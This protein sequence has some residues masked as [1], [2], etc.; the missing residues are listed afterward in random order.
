[1]MILGASIGKCVHVA[2]IMKFLSLA[3]DLG[4]EIHFLGPAVSVDKLLQAIEKYNPEIVAL[5]YRLSP[6][7]AEE[8]FKELSQGISKTG[9]KKRMFLGCTPPVAEVARKLGIFEWLVTEATPQD[10]IIAFLKG[11]K[12]KG[13]EAKYPQDL[14]ERIKYNAPFPLIRH[15]FGQPSLSDTIKGSKEIALAGVLD[16]LSLGPDQNAQEFFFR[17]NEIDSKQNGAGGVPLR[18]PDDLKVIYNATRC[19]NFPLLRCYSGT[20]DLLKWAEMSVETINNCWGAIPLSWYNR[21]DGRSKRPLPD[22]MKENQDVI[23]WYARQGVPVEVNESHQWSL[24]GAH[25][26]VAVAT[27]FLGAYN[28]KKLGVKYYVSQYM[29]NTPTGTS[30]RMDL[31][32]M[33]AKIALIEGLHDENFVSFRMVRA[34]LSSLSIIPEIAKGQMASAIYTGMFLKPHIVH[35][36]GYCEADHAARPDEIIESCK[37]A[38]GVIKDCLL[39]LPDIAQDKDIQKRKEELISESIFLLD[40]VKGLGKRKVSDPFIDTDVLT[41]AIKTGL[42]DAPNLKG[43][44]FARGE[45]VTSIINGCC[46]AIDPETCKT[47]SESER[48]SLIE[49]V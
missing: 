19:G 5:S 39:G 1:M 17:Q 3:Q 14:V 48:I 38:R 29:F 41:K 47:I 13:K 40:A 26:V 7:V 32:K 35:V 42:L 49:R 21:L 25:D 18:S 10:E 4:Y 22:S 37:I 15:H 36:V 11:E 9:L 46:V 24:R 44:E 43:N 34:G 28:A 31:A 6:Q 45:V 30:P 12:G 23:A 27:A 33:L 8:V 20:Q 16:I 2:G